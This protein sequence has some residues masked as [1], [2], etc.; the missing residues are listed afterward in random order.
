MTNTALLIIDVQNDFCDGG[1][2]GVPGGHRLATQISLHAKRYLADYNLIVA[3]A[4]WH[5]A[6]SDN[7]GH[8]S[9]HPDYKES[10]PAHCIA[11]TYGALFS[12]QLD[13]DILDYAIRKGQ[14]R[15]SYSA[16]EG[17]TPGGLSL[18]DL[19]DN[20]SAETVDIVGIA[21][22]HCVQ[23]TAVD[24]LIAGYNVRILDPLH[25]GIDEES[26][27]LTRIA[28]SNLGAKFVNVLKEE[29]F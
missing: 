15:P 26:V 25:L 14:G 19:L 1:S 27:R 29:L 13:M 18:N 20:S 5:D 17:V 10:W 2:L 4:D 9:D 22:E 23:A 24:A 21:T 12:P 8:I 11:E 28:L 6:D 3:S 16:F 7:G